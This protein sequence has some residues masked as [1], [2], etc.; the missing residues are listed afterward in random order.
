MRQQFTSLGKVGGCKG[1]IVLSVP[2]GTKKPAQG[3]LEIPQFMTAIRQLW[4]AR[5][6]KQSWL[7]HPCAMFHG[8]TAALQ[9]SAS[10][11]ARSYAVVL[12]QR[13]SA[14]HW[15]QQTKAEN[16]T[17]PFERTHITAPFEALFCGQ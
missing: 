1:H 15:A 9:Q 3:G 5:E 4:E 10:L 16:L 13:A 14:E 8:G 17:C 7:L 6:A 2:T 11:T 12:D